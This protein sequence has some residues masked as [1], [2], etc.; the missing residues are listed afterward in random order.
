MNLDELRALIAVVDTGSMIAAAKVTRMPRVSLRRRLDELEA[1][2]GVA[3]LVRTP[4]GVTATPAGEAMARSGRILLQQANALMAQSREIGREPT[5]VMQVMLPHGLPLEPLLVLLQQVAPH[6]GLQ[7]S[8]QYAADPL[9]EPLADMDFVLHFGHD[10]PDGPW[11]SY[12]LIRLHTRLLASREYLE[13]N[14]RPATLA[15]LNAHALFV[16]RS[17]E[18]EAGRLPCVD[19]ETAVIVPRLISSDIFALRRF[20]SLGMGIAYVPDPGVEFLGDPSAGLEQV[21]PEKVG[22]ATA[23]RLLV[24]AA[25]IDLP[26]VRVA[27][28][29]VQALVGGLGL[30]EPSILR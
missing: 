27:L 14:G 18:H 26:K 16:W 9:R 10:T 2:A 19:G 5:G 30:P 8:L 1:R 25:L 3:L 4:A 12:Q 15:D 17:P 6:K 21:L 24:P 29:L 13:A 23:L 7:I 28:D 22:Q 11:L 20:A